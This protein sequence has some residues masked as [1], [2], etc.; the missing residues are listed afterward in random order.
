MDKGQIIRADYIFPG[1]FKLAARR[2]LISR[3][4][5]FKIP[6]FLRKRALGKQFCQ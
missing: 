3:N 2:K 4:P 1:N 5:H 6:L